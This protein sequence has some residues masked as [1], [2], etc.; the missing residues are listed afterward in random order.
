M[1]NPHGQLGAQSIFTLLK[2]PQ[3][4][5]Q[6]VWERGSHGTSAF[7]LHSAFDVA[8][9]MRPSK[10]TKIFQDFQFPS[11]GKLLSV[12]QPTRTTQ[13]KKKVN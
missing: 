10:I 9:S 13:R 11:Q 3:Q 6:E 4:E 2:L 1:Q 8:I 12:Y 7:N 5:W